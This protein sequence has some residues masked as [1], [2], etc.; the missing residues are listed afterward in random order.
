MEIAGTSAPPSRLEAA[1]PVIRIHV[2]GLADASLGPGVGPCTRIVIASAHRGRIQY[3]ISV[4]SQRDTSWPKHAESACIMS[5]AWWST[6][7]SCP[8]PRCNRS[9]S[10]ADV[11]TVQEP[12]YVPLEHLV[13][14]LYTVLYL[15]QPDSYS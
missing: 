1:I 12:M 7:T 9:L 5:C 10:R 6:V 14:I 15:Y 4:L 8:F 2:A 3:S 13:W 11:A